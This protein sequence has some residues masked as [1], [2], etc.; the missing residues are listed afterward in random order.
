MHRFHFVIVA[1]LVLTSGPT[2][3]LLG[4][5]FSPA[6]IEFFEKQIRPLL[7]EHCFEC[8][9]EKKKEGGLKLTSRA[10]VLAGGDNG[11][12]VVPEKPDESSLLKAVEYLGETKMPPKGKLP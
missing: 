10:F 12:V 2:A 6:K 7:I 9:G 5:E 1:V 8:H 4:D 3:I 11:P